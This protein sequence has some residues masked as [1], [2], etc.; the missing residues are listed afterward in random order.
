MH[1]TDDLVSADL[2]DAKATADAVTGSS[3]AYLVA[4]LKYDA[5]VW[6]E[7]WPTVMRNAIDACKRHGSALVFFDNVYAYGPVDGAITEDTPYN[8]CSRK[9]EVRARI[10]TTFMDEVKRGELR[11]MIVRS[12]DFYGPGAVLSV[13][14]ATVIERLKAGKTPQWLGNPKAVHTL[15]YT[16]DA[17]RTLALLGNTETAYGQV[18]HAL[19]SHE[20]MTGEHFVRLAC[21]LSHRPYRLQVPPRWMLALLGAVVPIVRENMEMLYQFEHDYRFDSG[22]LERAFGLTATGY[23]DGIAATL[24]DSVPDV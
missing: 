11:G 18:W 22:R 7:Q 21:E 24:Q 3:V 4:G 9:G 8:P 19:T 5:R 10:A 15:T 16:Q 17:G 13:T 1:P 6:Q 20:P 23:R 14:H 12:A 2:L